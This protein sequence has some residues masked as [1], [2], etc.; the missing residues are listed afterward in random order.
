MKLKNIFPAK[1][2]VHL[3][4]WASVLLALTLVEMQAAGTT[5]MFTFGNEF[6]N[7]SFY[8]LI[9]YFNLYFLI[10][11]FLNSQKMG[12]YLIML[13]LTVA[14]VTPIKIVILYFKHAEYPAF[15]HN[16]IDNQYWYFFTSFIITIGSTIF[17]IVND[18]LIKQRE[19]EELQTQNIKTELN[20]LRSQINP[21][22]LFNTL[23][24]LY[25]LTLKKSDKAPEIV[26]K[27][28]EMMRYML[29]ECNEHQV[30]LA[31]EINYLKNYL[32]LEQLRLKHNVDIT[33]LT[34]GE[35]R[36]Q[37]IAPL[38][39]IP[40]V[41]NCFKHGINHQIEGGYIHIVFTIKNKLLNFEIENSKPEKMPTQP[42]KKSGGIG[43]ENVKRR[44]EL[45][46]PQHHTITLTDNPNSYKVA[47]KMEL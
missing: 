19:Q 36:D 9:I 40:F 13:A 5:F 30:S 39:F 45:L 33:V 42:T 4:V 41:E 38:L 25:A 2:L 24:N 35:V 34:Q 20:F 31:K 3:L 12:W 8:A 10:P 11:Q 32:D 23:N 46:Y 7:L 21:H 15:Q 22:F 29:Y 26:L 47:L 28:S 37:Q 16:L 6:I 14:L 27:L 18:W 43:L 17:A 1:L 44:L